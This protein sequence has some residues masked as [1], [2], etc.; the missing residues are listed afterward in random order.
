MKLENE[1]IYTRDQIISLINNHEINYIA[2]AITYLQVIG[3]NA[4]IRELRDKG[5]TIVNLILNYIFIPIFGCL[6]AAYTTLVGYLYLCLLCIHMYLV[7]RLRLS[8]VYSYRFV[9]LI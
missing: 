2:F 7:H 6:A 9:S 3:I 8:N 1:A 4:S 5:E